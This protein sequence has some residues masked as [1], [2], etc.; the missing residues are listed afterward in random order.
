MSKQEQKESLMSPPIFPE[1]K[2]SCRACLDALLAQYD[3]NKNE[4]ARG[5]D[6]TRNAISWWFTKGYV[7]AQAALEL[8]QRKGSPLKLEHMRPDM[9]RRRAKWIA[10]L[11]WSNVMRTIWPNTAKSKTVCR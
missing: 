9:A 10:V 5:L 2:A 11:L 8:E 6:Y 1:E 4:M 3:G 7:G